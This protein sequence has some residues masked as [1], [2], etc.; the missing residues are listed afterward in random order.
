MKIKTANNGSE[1]VLM[2][3][4]PNI[5][6]VIPHSFSTKPIL[7]HVCA[8]VLPK[9]HA[10]WQLLFYIQSS[11]PSLL[12]FLLTMQTLWSKQSLIYKQIWLFQYFMRLFFFSQYLMRFF[13]TLWCLATRRL[14]QRCHCPTSH[15]NVKHRCNSGSQCN[16]KRP[17]NLTQK[18][19]GHRCK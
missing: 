5:W 15:S 11:P 9:S 8:K 4:G 7:L 1:A 16:R 13:Q 2:W 14:I 18:P 6:K 3:K 12:D 17:K 10:W 19:Q